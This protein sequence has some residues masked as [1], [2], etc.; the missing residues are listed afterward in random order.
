MSAKKLTKFEHN[1]NFKILRILVQDLIN[2]KSKVQGFFFTEYNPKSKKEIYHI[3]IYRD[4]TMM[5]CPNFGMS[6]SGILLPFK[7]S[8]ILFFF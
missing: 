2:N 5:N 3:S 7:V 4:P 6:G 1:P 8:P